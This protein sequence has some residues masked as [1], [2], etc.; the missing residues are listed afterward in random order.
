MRY[1][2]CIIG[3]GAEGLACAATLAQ[4]GRHVL[5]VERLAEP[6]GRC[7]TRAFAPGFSASPFA[8]ELPAIPPAIFRDLELARRGAILTPA[9]A[10]SG[11]VAA[12]REAVIARVLADA[13]KPRPLFGFPRRR[14]APWP[15]EELATR[16]GIECGGEGLGDPDR[17]AL[18]LLAGSPGGLPRGGLGTL[19]S[20]LRRAA[21]ESGAELV[22]GVEATDIRRRHGRAVAVR[23]S[24]GRE[25]AA[26]AIVS[27]LDL[28]RTFLTLFAWN[29][30]PRPL[31]DRIA[32][33][34]A[35][36]GTARLL[37][38]L[39]AP[40]AV[41]DPEILRRPIP[42]AANYGE[43]VRAWAGGMI[44]DRPPAVLRL[45]SAV[46]PFLAPDGA[47]VLTVTLSAIPREPFDGPWNGDKRIV[48][49][50][51]ALKLVE[52]VFPGTFER[53][54]TAALIVPPDIESELGCTEGDLYGG[55]LSPSQMLSF[56]PFPECAGTRTPVKGLYLAGSS[57]AL[58]PL[59]TCAS[60]VAAAIAVMTDLRRGA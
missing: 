34:R 30:L 35:A 10:T 32:A 19:G 36:P 39:E 48:L 21:E 4:R 41:K 47:A 54:T 11:T 23:L 37:L 24:D 5:V 25:I 43:A 26:A 49:Q 31:V 33:F 2:V 51:R 22:C 40:P 55:A 20:A 28:K 46:D 13:A 7:V 56:R 17:G 60:G 14:Q 1:D 8:D 58:G 59:A 3:A 16:G 29:E 38:A 50:A 52:E 15:G 57:S 44:P 18:A 42:I 12:T 27:T 45:V 53:I 6:G 9:A